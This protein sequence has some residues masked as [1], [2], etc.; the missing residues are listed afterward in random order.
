MK[1]MHRAVRGISVFVKDRHSIS[2]LSFGAVCFIV[3][4]YHMAEQTKLCE[5][6]S[7]E[8]ENGYGDGKEYRQNDRKT[9][10]AHISLKGFSQPDRMINIVR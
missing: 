8:S 6:P 10:N 9:Q 2:C 3:L 4:I 1:M 7:C 5:M